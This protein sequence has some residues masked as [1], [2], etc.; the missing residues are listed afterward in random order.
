LQRDDGFAC[1]RKACSNTAKRRT[2]QANAMCLAK[3]PVLPRAIN[4]LLQY[5]L[6]VKAEAPL[7][8]FKGFDQR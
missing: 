8:R 7:L 6:R 4:L 1:L 3:R 5:R 2:A